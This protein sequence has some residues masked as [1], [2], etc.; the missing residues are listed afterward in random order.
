MLCLTSHAKVGSVAFEYKKSVLLERYFWKTTSEPYSRLM[1][2][3][4]SS[5][6]NHRASRIPT[7]SSTCSKVLQHASFD[8]FRDG[9]MNK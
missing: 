7:L 1:H 8:F 5:Y 6:P 2:S 3:N 9:L 4:P